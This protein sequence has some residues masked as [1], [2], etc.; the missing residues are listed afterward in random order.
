VE[1]G[2]ERRV[3]LVNVELGGVQETCHTDTVARILSLS[4]LMV[5]S[6]ALGS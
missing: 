4:E 2:G 1:L 6:T 3:D 5:A